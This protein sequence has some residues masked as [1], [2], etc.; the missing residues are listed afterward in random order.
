MAVFLKVSIMTVTD[1]RE[2]EITDDFDSLAKLHDEVKAFKM[3]D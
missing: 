3:N 1:K 2:E